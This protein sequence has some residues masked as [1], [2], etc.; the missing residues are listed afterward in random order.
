[1]QLNNLIN[2][3]D[4]SVRTYYFDYYELIE[5][6]E[7]IAAEKTF[8]KGNTICYI[9][10]SNTIYDIEKTPLN[11]ATE[12]S[13]ILFQKLRDKSFYFIVCVD[14]ENEEKIDVPD[15]IFLSL[16][17]AEEFAKNWLKK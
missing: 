6:H 3:L 7:F 13:K 15:N 2:D 17:E 10:M 5:E 14:D 16:K 1:M 8:K 9:L 11:Y 4:M 12:K